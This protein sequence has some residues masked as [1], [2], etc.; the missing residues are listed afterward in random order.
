MTVSGKKQIFN[1]LN[2]KIF[3]EKNS[4]NIFMEILFGKYNILTCSVCLR[5]DIFHEIDLDDFTKRNFMMGDTFLWLEY[6]YRSKIKHE[7]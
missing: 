1:D 7:S 5:S 4:S 3:I 6:A 2:S